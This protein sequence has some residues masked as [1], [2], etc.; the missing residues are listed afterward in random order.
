MI[1]DNACNFKAFISGREDS[2]ERAAILKELIYVVDK[3]HIQGHVGQKCLQTFHPKLFPELD[4][5]NTVVCEQCNFWLDKYKN[6]VKHM[7][8]YRYLFL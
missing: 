4:T 3:L 6:M 7:N 2:S 1:Y 8:L 5:I